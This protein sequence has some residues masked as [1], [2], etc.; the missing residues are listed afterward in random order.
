MI[1]YDKGIPKLSN[2]EALL[3]AGWISKQDHGSKQWLHPNKDLWMSEACAMMR[4]RAKKFVDAGDPDN[5]EYENDN[6]PVSYDTKM[7]KIV[8]AEFVDS[9]LKNDIKKLSIKPGTV[10][11]P[12][13]DE[14]HDFGP[15]D[16]RFYPGRIEINR[17]NPVARDKDGY[18]IPVD[19]RNP[20]VDDAIK[21]N[22]KARLVKLIDHYNKI[23]LLR[24]EL[25]D[26]NDP[27]VDDC[28]ETMI[29]ITTKCIISFFSFR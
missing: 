29:E 16:V 21:G 27:L 19:K 28:I 2:K 23:Q 25:P 20:L 11:G 12:A 10:F 14:G 15:T 26:Y 17:N 5:A 18:A 13:V 3:T 9:H 24:G 4:L 7:E 22:I 8:D 6:D 1:T